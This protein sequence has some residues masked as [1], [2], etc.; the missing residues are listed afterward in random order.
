[1]LAEDDQKNIQ[2]NIFN[3]F[4]IIFSLRKRHLK[5]INNINILMLKK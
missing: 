1:M 5:V 2:K 3:F 4:E